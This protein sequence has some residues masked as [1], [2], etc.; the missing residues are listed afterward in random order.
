MRNR[1]KRYKQIVH[2][3]EDHIRSGEYHV[4]DRIPSVN[5]WAIRFGIS[6]SSIFL[7]MNELKSRGLIEVEPSI[8][9]FV[10]SSEVKIQEKVLLLFNEFTAFKEDLYNAFIEAVG[11][12]VTTDI[13]FHNYNRT[14]FETLLRKAREK[15]T[16]YV[17]MPGKFDGLT[18]ALQDLPGRVILLDHC[19]PE[20][21]GQFPFIGQDFAEDSY[22]ALC[23][24]F[25]KIRKYKT[26]ILVQREE[27]IEPDERFFGIR[28]FCREYGFEPKKV[29]TVNEELLEKGALYITATDRE[30]VN[31]LKKAQTQNLTLGKDIGVVSY[32]E[33]PMKEVLCGGIT[34][35]STDF[36]QMG[37]T[38]ASM[39]R[40]KKMETISNPCTLIIRGS[41]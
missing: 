17:V 18:K 13:V 27:G 19:H 35:L 14:V 22:Q 39:V 41:I 10:A 37:K 12:D 33:T 25:K 29:D 6:R 34:T 8:G 21:K 15:Y 20:L 26:I 4:G 3:V 1:E 24:G 30:L 5:A 11:D 2:F 40:N 28:R 38:L 31:I 32:N 9:Y 36:K 7:A 16:T 23:Q